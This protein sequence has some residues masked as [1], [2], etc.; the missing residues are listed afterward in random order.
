M[1]LSTLFTGVIIHIGVYVYGEGCNLPMGMD[2]TN[3][4]HSC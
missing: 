3:K 4:E 1:S 2:E